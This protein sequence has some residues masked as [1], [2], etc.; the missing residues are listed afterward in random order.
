MAGMEQKT[1]QKS[2]LKDA[3]LQKEMFKK[4]MIV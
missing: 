3:K 4:S 1:L 2:K